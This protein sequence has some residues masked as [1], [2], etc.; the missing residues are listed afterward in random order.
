[1]LILLKLPDSF[2][3][4]MSNFHSR[5]RSQKKQILTHCRRE[6]MHGVWTIILD[7]D[8]LQACKYGIVI[9]CIDGVERRVYPR[10]FTYSADYP[11][12]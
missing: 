12:K 7:D 6:L 5:W 9:E 10:I 8:F 3:D 1:M 11:E 2:Q 4:F